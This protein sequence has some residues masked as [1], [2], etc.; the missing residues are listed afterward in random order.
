M[1]GGVKT[2]LQAGGRHRMLTVA[3]QRPMAL[4]A[5]DEA[6]VAFPS[7][8]LAIGTSFSWALTFADPSVESLISS[9]PAVPG[10]VVDIAGQSLFRAAVGESPEVVAAYPEVQTVWW[11][12]QFGPPDADDPSRPA[13]LLAVRHSDAIDA[14]R[15][16]IGISRVGFVRR[17]PYENGSLPSVAV[18]G[19]TCD[20][21]TRTPELPLATYEEVR[22]IVD[23]KPID[24]YGG[25]L[26][27]LDQVRENRYGEPPNEVLAESAYRLQL[28]R[29]AVP[30]GGV[31]EEL[32]EAIRTID[33]R[34]RTV[35]DGI[36]FGLNL[37]AIAQDATVSGLNQSEL[38]DLVATL[39][40]FA[41]A[42][43][44]RTRGFGHVYVDPSLRWLTCGE[45]LPPHVWHRL[46]RTLWS[47]LA[48]RPV[49]SSDDLR[50]RLRY[51]EAIGRLGQ[52]PLCEPYRPPADG[53]DPRLSRA[54]LGEAIVLAG[55]WL[56]PS[57]ELDA[58]IAAAVADG[59]LAQLRDELGMPEPG[60][61]EPGDAEPG[62]AVPGDAV[63]G[64]GPVDLAAPAGTLLDEA[65]VRLGRLSLLPPD[66]L[67]DWAVRALADPDPIARERWVR[68]LVRTPE[69]MRLLGSVVGDLPEPVRDQIAAVRRRL[70]EAAARTD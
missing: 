22:A 60:D 57:P 56:W 42:C 55:H 9:T 27:Y 44:G 10:D 38:A 24:A 40:R 36:D 62:D 35:D 33:R 70:A 65:L 48:E 23:P 13:G 4:F 17:W 46:H 29:Y 50:V 3:F 59:S 8:P 39:H 63:P 16:G 45:M 18:S 64:D 49:R 30:G 52:P 20:D 34:S 66:D 53:E 61:A 5:D 15:V 43:D 2:F 28:T 31:A 25:P 67:R 58:A 51:V 1:P 54:R 21:R 14:A 19:L 47:R 37:G 69:G 7:G 41:N 12:S 11:S 32:A 6:I 68:T 26:R